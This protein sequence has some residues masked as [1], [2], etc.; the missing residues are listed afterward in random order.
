VKGF[1]V[2]ELVEEWELAAKACAAS[3]A[4]FAPQVDAAKSPSTTGPSKGVIALKSPFEQ[5]YSCRQ[6]NDRQKLESLCY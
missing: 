6:W 4:L 3:F 5:C 1:S 2:L